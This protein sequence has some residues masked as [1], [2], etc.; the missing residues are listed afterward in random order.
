VE[1]GGV[2]DIGRLPADVETALFRIVQEGLSNIRRHSGCDTAS[3]RLQKGDTGIRLQISDCG[4]GMPQDA[5]GIFEASESG[6]GI[7]G[8]RQRLI[9]LGGRLEIESGPTGTTVTALVPNLQEQVRT[10]QSGA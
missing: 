7:C 4:H 10:Q 2:E 8:M 3:V 6:V 1:I 5:N 9:Q